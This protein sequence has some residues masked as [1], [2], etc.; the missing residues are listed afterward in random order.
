[1]TVHSPTAGDRSSVY[2]ETMT[3]LL[4]ARSQM[5]VS[6]GFHIIFAAI[7]IVMPVMMLLAEWRW[8]R[9]G[10]P[11]YL[12]LAKR[13]ASGSAILF[14]VG[15]VSGTVLSFELG[16]LWPHFMAWAGGAIGV[17]FSMEGFA[18]FT[19]AIFLGIYLYGWTRI[20]PRL[21]LAAGAL[22]ALS[23]VASAAFVV[24]ANGWMNTPAGI[25]TAN[26]QIVRVDPLAA[27]LNPS[28]VGEAIH[29]LLAAFIA[30]GFLAA[31]IHAYAL[32]KEPGHRLHQRA[33]AL[34]LL[35]GGLPAVLQPL[36]GD[37]LARHVA[38]HQPVKLAAFEAHFHTQA[39]A[40]FVLGGMVDEDAGHV[41]WAV[42]IP[43]LL[44]LLV[45]HDPG[46]EV[47]GLDRFPRDQWPPVGVVHLAFQ[48]M[49]AAGFALAVVTVWAAWRWWRAPDPLGSRPLLWSI[50]GVAP[51]GFVAIEAG[52][53]VTEVG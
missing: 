38:T 13:W 30:T 41:R 48:I 21:H 2:A 50:V 24:A 35:V 52:W 16:L 17:L 43:T 33:C 45:A 20:S 6:L 32:L 23:G 44:S 42:E 5:A 28:A 22:V 36:S 46:A 31:G 37:V 14:A 25:E 7:G 9:T 11:E 10:A 34:A 27:M 12:T 26:G 15:A 19:E 39:G 29:M 18:F 40:P 4:A 47:V 3:D 51:L 1:M 49:V 8:L 53:T